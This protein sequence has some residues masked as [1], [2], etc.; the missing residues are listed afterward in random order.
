MEPD[1]SLCAGELSLYLLQQAFS[2]LFE[3]FGLIVEW[4]SKGDCTPIKV[5]AKVV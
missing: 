2:A 5:N 3:E 4:A 1:Y